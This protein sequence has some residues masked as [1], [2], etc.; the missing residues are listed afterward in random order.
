MARASTHRSRARFIARVLPGAKIAPFPAYI[1]PSR[2]T[3]RKKPPTGDGWLHEITR[4]GWRVQARLSEGRTTIVGEG[5]EDCTEQFASIAAALAA[6]PANDIV[7]DGEVAQD[8]EGPRNP[9]ASRK[10]LRAGR[11]NG[12]VLYAFDLLYLDG[13]DIRAAPL[14]ERKRVLRELLDALPSRITYSDHVEGDGA[15]VLAHACAMGLAGIISKR[16]AAPHRPSSGPDWITVK[17]SVS[18]A[19]K[20]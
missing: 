7:L 11:T 12:L 10:E 19:K 15:T 3:A 9:S 5:G 2:V 18:A 16:A 14:V 13:F 4:D 1:A 6:I 17:C 8:G 20:K